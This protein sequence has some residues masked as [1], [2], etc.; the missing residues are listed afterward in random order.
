MII[1]D[2]ETTGLNPEKHSIVS[3]GAISFFNPAEYFYEECSVFDGAE[4]TIEA[5]QV[6]GFTEKEITDKNKKSL[7]SITRA[8]L[9]WIGNF[10]D[11]TLAGQ[12][13]SFD[14]NF[15]KASADRY[16]IEWISHNRG[17]DRTVD[18][19]SL[20]YAHHLKRRLVPTDLNT[21]KILNY[22]GLSDEPKPH[23]ALT[24]AKMVAEAISR[25]IYGRS[26]IKEFE[27]Y[28]VPSYLL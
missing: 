27:K 2:V 26:L 10:D 1:V 9:L 17:V 14:R 25:L 22:V 8:F 3:I 5:L 16:K 20:C 18:L 19:H 7:E 11:K 4:I 15:L 24:G 21:N 13:P 12:N 23:N 6:N 28:T